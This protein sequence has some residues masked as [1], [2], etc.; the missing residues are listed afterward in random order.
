MLVG[1]IVKIASPWSGA[2]TVSDSMWK[3]I[4]HFKKHS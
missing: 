4:G 1:D 2:G 3:G